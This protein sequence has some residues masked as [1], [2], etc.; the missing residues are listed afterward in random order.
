MERENDPERE[1]DRLPNLDILDSAYVQEYIRLRSGAWQVDGASR[2]VLQLMQSLGM[3]VSVE[4]PS[5]RTTR[6]GN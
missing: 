2:Q 6:S 3:R 1:H 4:I 5:R